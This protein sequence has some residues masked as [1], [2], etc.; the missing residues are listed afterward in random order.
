MFG[1][2]NS[3]SVVT[4]AWNTKDPALVEHLTNVALSTA[5]PGASSTPHILN[6]TAK[7]VLPPN[8]YTTLCCR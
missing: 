8:V 2:L 5:E 4:H 6:G 3:L 7:G 1:V